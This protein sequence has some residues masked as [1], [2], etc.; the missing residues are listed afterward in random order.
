M[1][2]LAVARSS[3]FRIRSSPFCA[4]RLASLKN[5]TQEKALPPAIWQLEQKQRRLGPWVPVTEYSTPPHRQWPELVVLVDMLCGSVESRW[6]DPGEAAWLL[7]VRDGVLWEGGYIAMARLQ[8][9]ASPDRLV[10]RH[11]SWP[12]ADAGHALASAQRLNERQHDEWNL[13]VVS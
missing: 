9:V 5:C 12:S 10:G 1:L 6:L 3:Y 4:S 7:G 2:P 11:L 8:W 13:C